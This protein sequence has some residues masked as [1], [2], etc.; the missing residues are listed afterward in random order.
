M[1]GYSLPKMTI[2]LVLIAMGI[3]LATPVQILAI[4]ENDRDAILHNIPFYDPTAELGCSIGNF[5]GNNNTE[6]AFN[7]FISKGLSQEQAAGVVGNLQWESNLDPTAVNPSGGAT[8][9]AQWKDSRLNDLIQ[10][11]ELQ[12]PPADPFTLEVQLNFIWFE[13][14]GEPDVPGAPGG[15]SNATAYEDLITRTVVSEAAASF[16]K[17]YERYHEANEYNGSIP[18][19]PGEEAAYEFAFNSIDGGGPRIAYAEAIYETY[20]TT[21]P[22]ESRG[23][24]TFT[25]GGLGISIDGFVFPLFTTKEV[26]LA[27]SFNSAGVNAVWCTTSL[28]ALSC[29]G[30]YPAADIF[31]A[32]GTQVVAARDGLVTSVTEEDCIPGS[33]CVGSRVSIYNSTEDIVYYY[34]HMKYGSIVVSEGEEMSAGSPIGLVGEQEQAADTWPH[35]HFDMTK[36]L[37]GSTVRFT[38][39]RV[40]NATTPACNPTYIDYFI[41]VQPL[42]VEGYNEL[43]EQ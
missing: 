18:P 36:P 1:G 8:G 38:C 29:H 20:A 13:L 7:Y 2:K 21:P 5:T 25:C 12:D 10:Y 11:A 34:T 4:S 41:N 19:A 27:G 6:I 32:V 9:I 31:V 42:L 39:K 15:N 22:P 16:A 3:I 37:N 40:A 30:D 43:P 17:Y 33:R 28:D 26:V 14:T 24:D 23:T 35:L